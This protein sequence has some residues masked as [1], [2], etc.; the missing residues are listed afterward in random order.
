[1]ML[2]WAVESWQ[3]VLQACQDM[4]SN[5]PEIEGSRI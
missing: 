5:E 2:R 3:C 1:M 4:W